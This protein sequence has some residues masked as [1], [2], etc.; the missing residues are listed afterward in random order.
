MLSKKIG[1]TIGMS[2]SRMFVRVCGR[3][4]GKGGT[5]LRNNKSCMG[6]NKGY[7]GSQLSNKLM[8]RAFHCSVEDGVFASLQGVAREE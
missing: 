8:W 7:M 5:S 4:G 3:G 1:N 6:P 2:R